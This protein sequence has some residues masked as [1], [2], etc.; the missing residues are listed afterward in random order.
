MRLKN[1]LNKLE[2]LEDLE[3]LEEL[4]FL[5][6]KLF[7]FESLKIEIA[8]TIASRIKT[9]IAMRFKSILMTQHDNSVLF[10]SI[11]VNFSTLI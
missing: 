11:F 5:R 3:D 8:K 9:T 2:D 7:F 6:E 10:L 4:N 1:F